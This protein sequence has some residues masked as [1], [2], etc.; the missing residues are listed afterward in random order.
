[1]NSKETHVRGDTLSVTWG[2]GGQM[3][4]HEGG[5][6]L[7]DT[8]CVTSN[9]R[10]I[11]NPSLN[12]AV[13]PDVILAGANSL[14]ALPPQPF[15][16]GQL[17]CRVCRALGFKPPRKR[18]QPPARPRATKHHPLYTARADARAAQVLAA[19]RRL[20]QDERLPTLREIAAAAGLQGN[21]GLVSHYMAR[22]A[23][24]GAVRR[25]RVPGARGAGNARWLAV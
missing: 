10:S 17:P 12:D 11:T 13:R 18:R 4:S 23:R 7:G 3:K 19:L 16:C 9:E 20:T 15:A 25:V 21:S 24:E 5:Y 6:T 22:L 8:L 1:M 2:I 14:T